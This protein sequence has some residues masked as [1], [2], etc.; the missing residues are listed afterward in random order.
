ML[1][2]AQTK[3]ELLQT[4]NYGRCVSRLLQKNRRGIPSGLFWYLV[5]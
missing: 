2:R 5:S 4:D 1:F 3:E